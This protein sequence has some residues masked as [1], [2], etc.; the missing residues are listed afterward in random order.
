MRV[1]LVECGCN[2]GLRMGRYWV[3]GESKQ[4]VRSGQPGQ[5]VSI[6][7]ADERVR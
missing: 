7:E 5:S 2:H 3:M 6:T 4:P 1:C